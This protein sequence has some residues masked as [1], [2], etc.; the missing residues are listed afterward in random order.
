MGPAGRL[1]DQRFGSFSVECL[2]SDLAHWRSADIGHIEGSLESKNPP[3]CAEPDFEIFTA[4]RILYFWLAQLGSLNRL[5][6]F[7]FNKNDDAGKN[8]PVWD[9]NGGCR[10][11]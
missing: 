6:N 3:D 8:Y 5:G 1:V 9:F 2:R 10:L 4:R 11:P 7:E